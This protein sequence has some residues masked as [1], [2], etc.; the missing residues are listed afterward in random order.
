MV[1]YWTNFAK[2]GDPNDSKPTDLPNW[3]QFDEKDPKVLA[4]SAQISVI[5]APDFSNCRK[6][7]PVL[8]QNSKK[9][10]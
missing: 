1:R 3:P 2:N 6:I 5:A 8:Q 9:Q 7:F 10:E 4:L